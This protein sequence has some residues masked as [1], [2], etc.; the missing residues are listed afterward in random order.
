MIRV[1]PWSL[2]V[3]ENT[4]LSCLRCMILAFSVLPRSPIGRN[5]RLNP[6]A[7]NVTSTENVSFVP[8]FFFFFFVAIGYP[9]FRPIPPLRRAIVRLIKKTL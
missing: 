9:S 1:V 5:M 2:M 6:L 8:P 4:R 7:E 3:V